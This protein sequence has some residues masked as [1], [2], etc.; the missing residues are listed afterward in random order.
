M[1][2]TF[3]SKNKIFYRQKVEENGEWI[4]SE[5]RKLVLNAGLVEEI[6]VDNGIGIKV[7]G[8]DGGDKNLFC[9]DVGTETPGI[10]IDDQVLNTGVIVFCGDFEVDNKTVNIG[11]SLS[12][13]NES[14]GKDSF[15][16]RWFETKVTLR[17]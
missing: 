8:G 5:I 10:L 17:N 12:A 14:L 11:F 9:Y 15:A 2:N 13:G 4:I 3:K 16:V 6:S 1:T 7:S